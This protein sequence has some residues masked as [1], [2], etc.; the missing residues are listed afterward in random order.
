MEDLLRRESINSDRSSKAVALSEAK[1][2][3]LR[4]HALEL[5]MY[6]QRILFKVSEKLFAFSSL[7]VTCNYHLQMTFITLLSGN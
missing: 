3:A 5:K 1:A 2:A 4:R 6:A 7:F